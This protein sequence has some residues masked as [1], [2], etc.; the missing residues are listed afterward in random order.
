MVMP[1]P[2]R[3][4]CRAEG[5]PLKQRRAVQPRTPF[6]FLLTCPMSYRRVVSRQMPA[7][8]IVS[9][10][11]RSGAMPSRAA[12]CRV[13]GLYAAKP[14]PSSGFSRRAEIS[15][16]S[17]TALPACAPEPTRAAAAHIGSRL[18]GSPIGDFTASGPRPIPPAARRRP[19]KRP[20]YGLACRPQNN[21]IASTPLHPLAGC[22][23]NRLR[24]CRMRRL[25][26]NG[27]R[28]VEAPHGF[29]F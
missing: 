4:A 20:G 12:W 17:G 24:V 5:T 16:A 21:T 13:G 22:P 28:W 18:A 23:D 1:A 19:P 8:A 27:S 6:W 9:S 29:L 15:R 11:P 3:C 14:W 7:A 2:G 25:R 26:L 10:H